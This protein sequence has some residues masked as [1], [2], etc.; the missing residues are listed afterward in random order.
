MAAGVCDIADA[1]VCVN[2]ETLPS[3]TVWFIH[4]VLNH[5]KEK[6]QNQKEIHLEAG[7]AGHGCHANS[8]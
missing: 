7:Q 3:T 5:T 8:F 6:Y 2:E 1:C 4:V